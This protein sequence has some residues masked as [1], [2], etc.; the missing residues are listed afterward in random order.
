MQGLLLTGVVVGLDTQQLNSI[1]VYFRL[2]NLEAL[3]DQ[4]DVVLIDHWLGVGLFPEANKVI[5]VVSRVLVLDDYNVVVMHRERALGE[6]HLTLH[7]LFGLA[8]RQL[9]FCAFKEVLSDFREGFLRRHY[10]LCA[11]GR[12]VPLEA[13]VAVRDDLVDRVSRRHLA[14]ALSIVGQLAHIDAVEAHLWPELEHVTVA[15]ERLEELA[16]RSAQLCRP[17]PVT[18]VLHQLVKRLPAVL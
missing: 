9:G 7:G 10:G 14:Q 6:K 1:E 3:P 2:V 4:L 13:N 5:S 11:D 8:E 18:V 17:C 15:L 12:A 16:S